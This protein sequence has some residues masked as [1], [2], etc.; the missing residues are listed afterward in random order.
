MT[1]A[2]IAAAA[3]GFDWTAYFTGAQVTQAKTVIVSENTAIPQIAKIFADAPLATLKA[4]EAFRT[5]DQ[6]A[7]LLSARFVTAQWTFRAKELS[8]AQAQRPRWKRG[9]G[10]V[11]TTIG[12]GL[13]RDYVAAYFPPESKAKME[14][15]VADLRGAL[16]ARIENLTW[17]S[18]E[19]KA[20]AI[21]KLSKFGVKIAYPDKWRDYSGLVMKADDLAGNMDRFRRL[22]L[23]VR[24]RQ[25]R[26]A[27]RSAG[28]GHDAANR[29]RL[30]F[31]GA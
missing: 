4:W 11:E 8:G 24:T 22:R 18:P 27:D 20:K 25:D 26:Q 17:M 14:G 10:F 23:G 19:T 2:E 12:E 5:S 9:I 7:P 31:A 30:L 6:A 21:E 29:Q 15:L 1:E 13:G 3:P 16:K 28:M